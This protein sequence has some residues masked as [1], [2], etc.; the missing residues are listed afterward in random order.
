MKKAAADGQFDKDKLMAYAAFDVIGLD[1][2]GLDTET[3][4][5]GRGEPR[6]TPE[7]VKAVSDAIQAAQLNGVDPATAA[8]R[9]H[10]QI[11][12]VLASYRGAALGSLL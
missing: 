11:T 1:R 8:A 5:Y 6:L 7:V 2:E 3:T 12:N 10:E 9:G 4:P